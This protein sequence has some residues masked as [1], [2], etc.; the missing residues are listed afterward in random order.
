MHVQCEVYGESSVAE[1]ISA[2]AAGWNANLIV[3]TWSKGGAIATSIGLAVA[4][5][6]TRGRHV[7]I[8]PDEE[9]KSEYAGAMESTGESPE[10]V[11]G[12]PEE[13]IGDLAGIDFLVVDCRYHDF[14]RIL[15]VAK[16]GQRGSVLVCKNA[17][18]R[19]SSEF[20]WRG[21]LGGGSRLVRSVFLPVGKGLDIAHVGTSGGERSSSGKGKRRWIKH[22]DRESGEVFVIRK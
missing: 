1:L 3:E 14:G 7:C 9:S 13:V 20:K 10:V 16:L 5:R 21:V 17:S 4:S 8:V 18:S 11:V 19:D 12:T 6:H 15:R 2:M 22:T